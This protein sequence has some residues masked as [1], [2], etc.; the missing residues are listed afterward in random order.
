MA[1]YTV[2]LPLKLT[3]L[4]PCSH[5]CKVMMS[6]AGRYFRDTGGKHM[7]VFTCLLFFSVLSAVGADSHCSVTNDFISHLMSCV[8]V[9][10]SFIFDSV[11]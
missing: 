4:S 10:T 11:T 7:S 8:S 9:V 2:L 1:N 3:G 5:L 6:L